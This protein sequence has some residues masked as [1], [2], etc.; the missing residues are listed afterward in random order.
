MSGVCRDSSQV[1]APRHPEPLHVLQSPHPGV[2]GGLVSRLPGELQQ[3]R[4]RCRTVTAGRVLE[5]TAPVVAAVAV[6]SVRLLAADECFRMTAMHA[7]PFLRSSGDEVNAVV[8]DVGP[9]GNEMGQRGDLATEA[10]HGRGE[11]G[12]WL[13]GVVRLGTV[14]PTIFPFDRSIKGSQIQRH[15]LR[16]GARRL[17]ERRQ[18]VLPGSP[19]NGVFQ[20]HGLHPQRGLDSFALQGH[21]RTG[22]AIEEIGSGKSRLEL[23]VGP[24]QRC[25]SLGRPASHQRHG[26]LAR[27]GSQAQMFRRFDV[28]LGGGSLALAEILQSGKHTVFQRPGQAQYRPFTGPGTVDDDRHFVVHGLDDD[29]DPLSLEAQVRTGRNQAKSGDDAMVMH[30]RRREAHNLLTAQPA[31]AGAVPGRLQD[32]AAHLELDPVR[33]GLRAMDEDA[34]N[35]GRQPDRAHLQGIGLKRHAS[36]RRQQAL[37]DGRTGDLESTA[38]DGDG[39]RLTIVVAQAR[40]GSPDPWIRLSRSPE[41]DIEAAGG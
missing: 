18:T 19:E 33:I 41:D 7:Q 1:W 36:L 11:I 29:L 6:G 27:I 4:R 10:E 35:E 14:T 5:M 9:A 32:S 21:A 3:I 22:T 38:K 37:L 13:P 26:D 30:Q 40:A 34:S 15:L 39:P 2:A 31:Q 25:G 23:H 24:G 8:G 20:R 16:R 12:V 28:Q 17:G